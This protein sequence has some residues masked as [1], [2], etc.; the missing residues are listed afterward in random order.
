MTEEGTTVGGET[1]RLWAE[2]RR[3][4]SRRAVIKPSR[5]RGGSGYREHMNRC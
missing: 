3:G 1:G 2:N 5:V 4:L